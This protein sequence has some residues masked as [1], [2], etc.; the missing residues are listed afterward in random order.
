MHRDILLTCCGTGTLQL[1]LPAPPW[2]GG[3]ARKLT[4]TDPTSSAHQ[5]GIGTGGV[6][7]GVE[8]GA[9]VGGE[10]N[11]ELMGGDE[12]LGDA[13]CGPRASYMRMLLDP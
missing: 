10:G 3:R 7:A 5:Q 9:G 11:G 4:R 2:S 6:E 12:A 1:P 13:V 8:A